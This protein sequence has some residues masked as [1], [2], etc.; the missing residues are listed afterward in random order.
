MLDKEVVDNWL[1][2]SDEALLAA[3]KNLDI[4]LT[5]AQNRVYYAIFYAVSALAKA[6]NFTTAKHSQ[7][8]GWFNKN[9]VATTI[10]DRD[11]AAIYPEM[12]EFR[13]KCDY[14]FTFKPQREVLLQNLDNAQ[15]FV[16]EIK[17]LI[18]V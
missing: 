1:D 17:K 13:Q 2:K 4:P 8:L 9:Y 7:L 5:T 16:A 6:N 15:K 10:V 12:Y 18:A 11:V 3:E 14:S